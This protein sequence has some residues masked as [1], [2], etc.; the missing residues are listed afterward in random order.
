V[1]RIRESTIVLAGALVLAVTA[2]ARAGPPPQQPDDVCRTCH[3]TIGAQFPRSVHA[4]LIAEETRGREAGCAACHGEGAKHAESADPD[5]VFSFKRANARDANQACLSCHAEGTGHEWVGSG[6]AISGLSCTDCHR[7]H[8]SRRVFATTEKAML[9]MRPQFVNAPPPKNSLAKPEPQLC[10][11]C[12]KEKTAQM[13]FSSHHPV[14]EGKMQCSSCHQVHGSAVRQLRTEERAS[15][16]CLKC[17]TAKQGPFVFEHAPV[18]ENCMTCH[19]PHG[20]VANNLLRQNEPFLCL[21]C[22]EAHFHLGRSGITTPLSL[23]SGTASNKYG[24]RGWRV[25]FATKCTQ[26]HS[27]IH[28]TDLPG[29]SVT[30]R[31][32]ALTR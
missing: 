4:R 10:L 20:T 17:H 27:M 16:L 19:E 9:A 22:H 13:M 8:Q 6:H 2:I 24:E 12:H 11:D 31:G 7:I 30:S 1:H 14:R 28:G 3:E 23:P 5:Q 21:Q 15:D 32:K 25:A 18:A 26:C 29:Q